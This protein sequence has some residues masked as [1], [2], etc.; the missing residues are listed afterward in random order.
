MA[1]IIHSQLALNHELTNATP[2]YY[3]YSPSAVLE[4]NSY[5]L[6]WDRS[7]ITDRTISANRPDIVL[8]DKSKKHTLLIDIAIP[9]THRLQQSHTEKLNKYSELAEEIKKMWQQDKVSIIP[10]IVSSTGVIPHNLKKSLNTLGINQHSISLIQK[11][12]ILSTCNIVRKF[13]NLPIA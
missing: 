8:T 2:P 1:K 11:A 5:R 7:V 13:L 12:V 3:E 6:Y 4:N 9:N 10:I